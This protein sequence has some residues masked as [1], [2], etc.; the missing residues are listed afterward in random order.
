MGTTVTCLLA[1][2][3]N[4]S[5]TATVTDSAGVTSAPSYPLSFQVFSH[6]SVTTPSANR[7]A[8]DVG[9]TVGFSEDATGGPGRFSSYSWAGLSYGSC[10]GLTTSHPSCSF[11]QPGLLIVRVNATDTNGV[12]TASSLALSLPIS[13]LPTVSVTANRSTA[14]VSQTVRFTAIASGGYGV[15][16]YDWTETPSPGC[17]GS[18]A[19]TVICTVQT[20]GSIGAGVVVTDANGG[21]SGPEATAWIA[22]YSE[23]A[24]WGVALSSPAVH[25]GQKVLVNATATGGFGTYWYNWSGLPKGC[26]VEGSLATCYPEDGG[27]Y[28]ISL[29]VTDGNGYTV[30][31][32]VSALTVTATG[33][34]TWGPTWTLLGLSP[35]VFYGLIGA[36]VVIA[37]V[38]A[39]LVAR[40]RD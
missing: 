33:P 37:G 28:R 12:S 13:S 18:G 4:F 9:Q 2:A 5:I 8:A 38:A 6:P 40:K 21:Q 35:P 19:A 26:T 27:T 10:T 17:V 3:G 30:T 25:V 24:V 14:D 39:L 32:A 23:L 15:Y 20:S 29:T 22:S 11:S 31:T 1:D 7:S 36:A 16:T 34:S